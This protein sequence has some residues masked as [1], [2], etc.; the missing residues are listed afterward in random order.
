MGR[1]QG[2][3]RE[4]PG[5]QPR[6]P[7][8]VLRYAEHLTQQL[9]Q[10]PD[11]HGGLQREELA[12]SAS[13]CRLLIG[14]LDL[15]HALKTDQPELPG[16]AA[17]ALRGMYT[18]SAQLTHEVT[19]RGA[20]DS[21]VALV[22]ICFP[23]WE[24]PA[25]S[26]NDDICVE[27][28]S[29]HRGQLGYTAV[30][31]AP[32]ELLEQCWDEKGAELPKARAS[33]LVADPGWHD[34]PP[35]AAEIGPR[36]EPNASA[37]RDPRSPALRT[38]RQEAL[39]LLLVL[40]SHGAGQ[41]ILTVEQS[42][43]QPHLLEK[44][45]E[46]TRSTPW[47][48]VPRGVP[49]NGSIA[50]WEPH[51]PADERQIRLQ[52]GC[53][54]LLLLGNLAGLPGVQPMEAIGEAYFSIIEGFEACLIARPADTSDSK[55]GKYIAKRG[56]SAISALRMLSQAHDTILR[57]MVCA[58]SVPL[59]HMLLRAVQCAALDET[60]SI[61]FQA[62]AATL[63]IPALHILESIGRCCPARLVAEAAPQGALQLVQLMD[64]RA[65]DAAA[66]AVKNES[67]HRH[68][69]WRRAVGQ[70]ASKVLVRMLVNDRTAGEVLHPL[71]V[72][73][74]SPAAPA[75]STAACAAAAHRGDGG[76]LAA[77]AANVVWSSLLAND[78]DMRPLL[79]VLCDAGSRGG[80]GLEALHRWGENDAGVLR[81]WTHPEKLGRA[82]SALS[83]STCAL[84]HALLCAAGKQ[85]IVPESII[86]SDFRTLPS[87]APSV[88][89]STFAA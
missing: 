87:L 30:P 46:L 84:L 31:G 22:H 53:D 61:S 19:T 11:P 29:R 55:L 39:Q 58:P 25:P 9:R 8:D 18:A 50:V 65:F 75:V 32:V 37:S 20:I 35:D 85:L 10:H 27:M 63:V 26:A 71:L 88:T 78:V 48:W 74:I 36:E 60:A 68:V 34:Y 23:P 52:C 6:T 1:Y 4:V 17:A 70:A 86:D 49:G 83:N 13:C 57:Q 69:G 15:R 16:R 40:C 41:Y 89:E 7:A 2:F 62:E 51:Y 54:A 24:E 45:C 43:R 79:R 33:Q 42:S 66:A 14:L 3:G 76:G 5:R 81:S 64:E 73:T 56:C 12:P 38:A 44:L 80:T 59:V 47:R 67:L 21:I 77:C 82:Q 28:M 72:A